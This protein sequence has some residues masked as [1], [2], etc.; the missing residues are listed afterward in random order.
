MPGN[1]PAALLD[2]IAIPQTLQCDLTIERQLTL[3]RYR[4]PNQ[5]ESTLLY[6]ND[7]QPIFHAVL[8]AS[9]LSA[10]SA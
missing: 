1:R 10:L 9:A 2:N 4:L 3:E 5:L 6:H 8:R 7:V